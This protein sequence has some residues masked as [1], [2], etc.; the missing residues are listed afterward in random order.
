MWATLY[1]LL[2]W[3]GGCTRKCRKMTNLGDT[4]SVF[5]PDAG[6]VK[7]PVRCGVCGQ[8]MEEHLDCY[9]PISS[10]ESMAGSKHHHDLFVCPN[11]EEKWHRQVVALRKEKKETASVV[12]SLILEQEI[13]VVLDAQESTKDWP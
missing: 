10:V 5:T 3:L 12:I 4:Q 6:R 9:G 2:R 8:K 13:K 1:W 11:R 7:G